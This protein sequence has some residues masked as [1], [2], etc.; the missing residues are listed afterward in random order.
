MIDDI[1]KEKL[2]TTLALLESKSTQ[3]CIHVQSHRGVLRVTGWIGGDSNKRT[4][5]ILGL[6]QISLEKGFTLETNHPHSKTV[7]LGFKFKLTDVLSIFHGNAVNSDE[8]DNDYVE[9]FTSII[10]MCRYTF[11]N[12]TD[13]QRTDDSQ[14]YKKA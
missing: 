2:P 11:V 8:L 10:Y 5:Q 13:R 12:D 6:L 3:E 14:Y 4:N 9:L 7:D 1:F